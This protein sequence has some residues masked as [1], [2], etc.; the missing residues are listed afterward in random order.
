MTQQL[1]AYL[2][3]ITTVMTQLDAT[4][5]GQTPD[6]AYLRLLLDMHLEQIHAFQ[7]ER[8]IHLLVT[9]FFAL[10]LFACLICT[11]VWPGW[12]FLALDA[13]LITLLGFYIGHY[14]FLENTLQKLYPITRSLYVYL[15]I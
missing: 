10:V 7:H 14:Y 8:L 9:F 11:A 4:Q 2:T 5:S 12:Q 1:K 3:F 6:K 15:G 13:I